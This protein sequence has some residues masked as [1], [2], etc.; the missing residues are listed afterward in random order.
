[1]T[2]DPRVALVTGASRG[3]GLAIAMALA[4]EGMRVAITGRRTAALE[5]AAAEFEPDSIL[6][7][8]GSASDPE[9]RQ[10]AVDRVIEH[11]GS[12]DVLVNNAGINPVAAPLVDTDLDAFS[13]ILDTNLVGTLGWTQLAHRAWLGEHGGAVVNVASVA[14]LRPARLIGAYGASK[15]GLLLLTRQ[16]A[17]ELGPGVRVNAIAPAVVRTEFARSLYAEREAEVAAS[18]PVGRFGAPADVASAVVYLVSPEANWVS[19]ETLVVD[20]GLMA[21]GGIDF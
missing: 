8:A 15:A 14:G 2:A 21:T 11:F 1:M 4:A 9:H 16:L 19:G 20:G 3:I 7:L 10:N 6:T 5:E 17:V 18:Y 12:L 13:R